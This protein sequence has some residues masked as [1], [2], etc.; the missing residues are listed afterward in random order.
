MKAYI[1][2]LAFLSLGV[3]SCQHTIPVWN[4]KIYVGVPEHSAIERSQDPYDPVIYANEER[5]RGFLCM[6]PS[7]YKSFVETYVLSCEKWGSNTKLAPAYSV[8]KQVLPEE[9]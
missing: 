5:F 7:D 1:A 3:S 9:K 4:G 6:S 8:Q 2:A